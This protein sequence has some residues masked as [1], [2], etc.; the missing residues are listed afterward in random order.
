MGLLLNA[1]K[2]R[3]SVETAFPLSELPKVRSA[4]DFGSR[5]PTRPDIYRLEASDW[6]AVLRPRAGLSFFRRL[7]PKT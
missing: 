5:A 4:G 3:V 2:P 7:F 1:L 6:P